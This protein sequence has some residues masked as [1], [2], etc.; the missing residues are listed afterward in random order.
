[1]RETAPRRTEWK[2]LLKEISDYI[3]AV[4]EREVPKQTETEAPVET[5]EAKDVD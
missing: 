1:M 3:N 2:R 4:K 5:K